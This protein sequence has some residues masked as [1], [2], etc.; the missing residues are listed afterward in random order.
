MDSSDKDRLEYEAQILADDMMV[1]DV[2]NPLSSIISIA[3]MLEERDLPADELL[4]INR[5]SALG[6]RAL[7][8]LKA[9][10]GYAQMEQ[11]RYEAEADS[12]DLL[13]VVRATIDKLK[14]LVDQ[15]A[16]PVQIA[17]DDEDATHLKE[18]LP[19]TADRFFIEQMLDNL[20]TNALE[21]SPQEEV[22]TV[23]IITKGVL[24]IR[25]HNQGVVPEEVR[26]KVFSKAASY[27]R[28]R[29]GGLGAHIAQLV[30]EQ[31]GGKITFITS[32]SA[33]TTF[34]AVLPIKVLS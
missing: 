31:H 33:G 12:F 34:R 18:A 28:E 1:H 16:V 11:G 13:A 29:G 20:L 8:V 6:H 5:I 3:N 26:D 21:A 22:V 4:W 2:R 10:S 17:V 9:S 19:V 25:I 15:R 30:A 23:S 14:T 32:E 7:N 24:E 27:Q